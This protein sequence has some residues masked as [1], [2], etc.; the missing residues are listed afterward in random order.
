MKGEYGKYQF[1][2]LYL[3]FLFFVTYIS[4]QAGATLI[5]NAPEPPTISVPTYPKFVSAD[6]LNNMTGTNCFYENRVLFTPILTEIGKRN[7]WKYCFPEC[8]NV[9]P[10]CYVPGKCSQSGQLSCLITSEATWTQFGSP[11]GAYVGFFW[12]SIAYFFKL[13][14]VST[15]FLIFGIL[16]ITPFIIVLMLIIVELIQGFIPG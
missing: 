9:T 5:K 13:M 7:T 1:L 3:V 14:M 12:D 2:F 11:I 16:L 8:I 10:E 6:E 15:E 4:S